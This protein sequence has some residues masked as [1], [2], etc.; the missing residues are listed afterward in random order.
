MKDN[1]KELKKNFNLIRKMDWIPSVEE[2][3]GS[4]GLTL[5]RL[6]NK[7]KENFEIPDYLGIE[8][9]THKHWSNA[10]TTLFTAT[11]DGTYLFEIKRIKEKYGYPDKILKNCKVLHGSVD[12]ISIRNIGYKYRFKLEVD[13]IKE[14]IYLCVYKENVLIEKQ[15]YWTFQLL[16]E[17]LERKLT[18]LAYIYYIEKNIENKVYY[19]Y[20]KMNI[21]KLK[22]FSYFIKAVEEGI[23]NVGFTVG[24]FRTGNRKGEIHDHGT[25]FRISSKNLHYIY[26]KI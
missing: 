10:D 6:L 14:R 16:K 26:S 19:K 17:K 2:G 5:E 4:A 18:Y 25:A 22:N 11:P 1:L 12:A 24:V 9:K 7:E 15:T 23:I 3:K 13:Y 8:L 21:Y 20:Y